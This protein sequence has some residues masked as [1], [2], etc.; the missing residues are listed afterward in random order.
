[1][2]ATAAAAADGGAASAPADGGREL[3][4]LSVD[5]LRRITDLGHV[6]RLLAEVEEAE[7]E[8]DRALHAD[9]G[10]RH[11]LQLQ[12]E[13]LDALRPRLA[14]VLGD[15]A[16]LR[17]TVVGTSKLAEAVSAKVRQL[18]VE[19]SRVQLAISE[20]EN[21]QELKHCVSGVRDAIAS[22]NYETAAVYIHR[23]LSFDPKVA[24]MVLVDGE[25]SSTDVMRAAEQGAHPERIS[26]L[27]S[28][29]CSPFASCRHARHHSPRVC[30]GHQSA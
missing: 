5:D 24:R 9:L 21:I 18:D 4:R 20:L 16:R 14:L 13:S 6:Q 1:M 27:G 15:V 23:Y 7:M 22:G 28:R 3:D 30:R 19:Q 8:I 29:Q 12:L 26:P 10:G 2:A 25:T 17:T 11:G